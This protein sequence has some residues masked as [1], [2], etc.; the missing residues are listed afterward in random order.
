MPSYE[1]QKMALVMVS[2]T[3]KDQLILPPPMSREKGPEERLTSVQGQPR[4]HATESYSVVR[5]G[6]AAPH[7]VLLEELDVLWVHRH[8]RAGGGGLQSDF[9]ELER[10]F[11]QGQ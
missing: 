10:A 2:R 6:E 7:S 3:G 11:A 8:C 5:V 4:V 1:P 9:H